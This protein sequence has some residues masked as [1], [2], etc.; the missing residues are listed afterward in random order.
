MGPVK[1]SDFFLPVDLALFVKLCWDCQ[2]FYGTFLKEKLEDINVVVDEWAQIEGQA[3]SDKT[4]KIRSHHPS[5][6]SFPGLPAHAESNKTQAMTYNEGDSEM[7]ISEVTQIKGIPYADYFTVHVEWRC[8][9][10]VNDYNIGNHTF[11]TISLHFIFHK[12]TWLQGT[13]ESNTQSEM[14]DVFASWYESAMERIGIHFEIADAHDLFKRPVATRT[15]LEN[16]SVTESDS[17]ELSEREGVAQPTNIWNRAGLGKSELGIRERQ[18]STTDYDTDDFHESREYDEESALMGARPR[19]IHTF[20]AGALASFESLRHFTPRGGHINMKERPSNGRNP[21]ERR[22]T[23]GGVSL[24]QSGPEGSDNFPATPKDIAIHIVEALFVLMEFSFWQVHSF[25]QY[26]LKEAFQVEASEVRSRTLRA[27]VPWLVGSH[28]SV[29]SKPDMYGPL[30][31]VFLLPQ[32]LLWG[33][34][35]PESGCHRSEILGNAIIVCLFIWIGLS[36]MFSAVAF[37]AAP[38]I[39]FG[40][41]LCV[42]GYSFFA[43]SAAVFLSFIIDQALDGAWGWGTIPLI[44]IGIPASFGEALLFWEHTK[45]SSMKLRPQQLASLPQLQQ[46]VIKYSR[47][48]QRLLYNLPKLAVFIFVFATHYQFMWYLA[49]VFLPGKKQLCRLAALVQPSAYTDILTQKEAIKYIHNIL[50]GGGK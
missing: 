26:S 14:K 1:L 4:R 3:P 20:A 48:F 30:L 11:V 38:T 46:F 49:R 9:E 16:P 39:R 40:H 23:G 25:Y 43:W 21:V 19:P 10:V 44:L 12:S 8:V 50:A 47:V 34:D 35:V 37:F 33:M 17:E 41:C 15:D 13:I 24:D 29:L 42:T 27:F 22:E 6:I 18:D 31:A 2:D 28:E 32:V 7:A 36:G 45:E 5:K